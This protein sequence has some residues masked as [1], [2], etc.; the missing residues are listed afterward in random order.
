MSYSYPNIT[1]DCGGQ[2]TLE[3][4]QA[5]AGNITGSVAY[6]LMTKPR[7]KKDKEEGKLSSTAMS[8][9]KKKAVEIYAGSD[10][11]PLDLGASAEMR[12]GNELEDEAVGQYLLATNRLPWDFSHP[13]FVQCG[14]YLGFSPDG[15]IG[16]SGM[17]EVKCP[18]SKNAIFDYWTIK[19]AEDLK[20][21][22]KEYYWQ[23]Q[24]TLLLTG[25]QW[26]DFIVYTP[27]FGDKKSLYYIRIERVEEDIQELHN[28]LQ[29]AVEEIELLLSEIQN[30]H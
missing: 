15:L 26:C 29:R 3:W 5:R 8:Y 21:I 19:S 11:N 14:P 6:M 23:I 16:D 30:T 1:V 20:R 27:Q 7:S 12:R 9:L 28:V 25:R 22:K 2:G 18:T 24:Y 17:I 10:Y 4:L 13:D